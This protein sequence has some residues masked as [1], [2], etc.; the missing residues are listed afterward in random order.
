MP[1]NKHKQ[2]MKKIITR[3]HGVIALAIALANFNIT[4]Q[5]DGGEATTELIPLDVVDSQ[6]DVPA[7]SSGLKSSGLVK[8]YSQKYFFDN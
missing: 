8:R 6:A 1:Q 4:A 5:D 2:Q 7:L 3:K